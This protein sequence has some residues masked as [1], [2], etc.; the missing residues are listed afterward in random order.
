MTTHQ[1]TTVR[2]SRNAAPRRTAHPVV[3]G[4]GAVFRDADGREYL[5]LS[6]QTVNLLFGQVHP[7]ITE[8]VVRRVREYTFFDQDLHCPHDL[9]ALALLEPLLPA[10][11]SAVN[12]KLNNGSDAVE[13]AVKQARRATG[14]SKV[15]TTEGIYLG[16]STQAINLR[17]LG[18]RPRDILRGSTEDVVFAPMPYCPAEDH[19]PL[20]C[21][22]ENGEAICALVDAH[23]R[24]LAAVLLDPIMVTSGVFGGRA[25]GTLLRRVRAHTEERGVPLL[26]DESQTFGWV[27]D[28]TLAAHWG[29]LPDA[30]ALGK[31]IAGGFPLALCATG[32][33]LDVLEWGE[34]DFTHGGHPASIAAM[35]A[36]CTL[37]ADEVE[38]KDFDARVQTLDLLLAE[39]LGARTR[40]RGIGLIRGV[41]V[42]A[43]GRSADPALLRRIADRCFERGV[44]VRAA[45]TALTVKPP[46]VITVEQLEEA[47]TVLRGAIR[48]EAGRS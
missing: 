4:A 13:C 9:E 15:I 10:G 48:A 11:L 46:R 22:I 17:G 41:E 27:P 3:A 25:M 12:L 14:R 42:F 47:F 33:R 31:G 26:L 43:D 28:Y 38:Q 35:G 8:R 34:A 20:S 44:H 16:Q 45:R 7:F 30:M 6:S 2:L 40:V 39:D 24:E 23:L 21:P 37:L 5:D 18:P 19:D 36:T 29:V 32:E 1:T